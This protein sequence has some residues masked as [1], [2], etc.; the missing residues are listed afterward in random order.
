M[1]LKIYV[2]PD[3]HLSQHGCVFQSYSRVSCLVSKKA[4][5][6]TH[7]SSNLICSFKNIQNVNV[8]YVASNLY[9]WTNTVV[10][11]SAHFFH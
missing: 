10:G 3:R 4:I 7:D 5:T 9:L 2:K 11:M 8:I 1:F 6:Y